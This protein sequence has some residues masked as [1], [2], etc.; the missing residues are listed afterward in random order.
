MRYAAAAKP[1]G[2]RLTTDSALSLPL[3][4]LTGRGWGEGRVSKLRRDFHS[5]LDF[6]IERGGELAADFDHRQAHFGAVDEAASP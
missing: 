2:A 1:I 3:P 5:P 6:A 4:V